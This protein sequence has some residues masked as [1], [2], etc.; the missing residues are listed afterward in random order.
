MIV[1]TIAGNTYYTAV[2]ERATL[3]VAATMLLS[4]LLIL[5]RYR[6]LSSLFVSRQI[7]GSVANSSYR[8]QELLGPTVSIRKPKR[9]MVN[10]C[11][12]SDLAE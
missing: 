11:N 4:I 1:V 3:L 10:L 12:A 5:R 6:S 8:M 9:L 7:T 2:D